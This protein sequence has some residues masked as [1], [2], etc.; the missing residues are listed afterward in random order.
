MNLPVDRP[1]SI[2]IGAPFWWK[3]A[4]VAGVGTAIDLL[5][6]PPIGGLLAPI[7]L[8]IN[9]LLAAIELLE[10]VLAL[11]AGDAALFLKLG[12]TLAVAGGI[13]VNY[14]TAIV[15]GFVGYTLMVAVGQGLWNLISNY[16]SSRT[17]A[18]PDAG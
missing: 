13:I 15:G 9:L 10:F 16:R 4:V 7:L 12:E 6:G 5:L 8:P 18:D 2:W 14:P 11:T 17:V 1:T 3:C